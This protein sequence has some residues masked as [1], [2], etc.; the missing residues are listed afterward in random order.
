MA[1]VESKFA[2]HLSRMHQIEAYQKEEADKLEV[3][4]YDKSFVYSGLK[5]FEVDS[6][7]TSSKILK[8]MELKDCGF[9]LQYPSLLSV[10]STSFNFNH[11]FVIHD[12]FTKFIPNKDTEILIC[13]SKYPIYL[14]QSDE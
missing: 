5:A 8:N 3:E 11:P 1:E 9:P 2:S 6:A 10:V 13:E 12:H 4:D 7:E 14:L